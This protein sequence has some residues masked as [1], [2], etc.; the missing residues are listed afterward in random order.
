MENIVVIQ[1]LMITLA[2][3]VVVAGAKRN[4]CR[5]LCATAILYQRCVLDIVMDLNQD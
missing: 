2:G 4:A 1:G 5:R 3:A